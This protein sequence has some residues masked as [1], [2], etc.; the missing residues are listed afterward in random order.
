MISLFSFRHVKF[1]NNLRRLEFLKRLF[2]SSRFCGWGSPAGSPGWRS[3]SDPDVFSE[4]GLAVLVWFGWPGCFCVCLFD[5]FP[6]VPF[7]AR[8][9]GTVLLQ[10][11]WQTWETNSLELLAHRGRK[12]NVLAGFP[13]VS[14]CCHAP[15]Q[16]RLPWRP[17]PTSTTAARPTWTSSPAGGTRWTTSRTASRSPTSSPTPTS[18]YPSAHTHT[19][20]RTQTHNTFYYKSR[21]QSGQGI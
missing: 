21:S 18:A 5:F 4:P 11:P 16:K 14:L 2:S 20:T 9:N 19:H 15:W 3:V 13:R 12:R 17:G 10:I 8:G 6:P 7:H 1:K